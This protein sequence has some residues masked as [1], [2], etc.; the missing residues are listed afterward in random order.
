MNQPPGRP[1]LHI[2]KIDTNAQTLVL[3]VTVG[4]YSV[5]LK[6]FQFEVR[7]DAEE[8]YTASNSEQEG[9]A[10]LSN[11]LWDFDKIQERRDKEYKDF[12]R[13]RGNF[14]WAR[15]DDESVKLLQNQLQDAKRNVENLSEPI[16]RDIARKRVN[17]LDTQLRALLAKNP[18]QRFTQS[19]EELCFCQHMWRRIYQKQLAS[20]QLSRHDEGLT[21]VWSEQRQLAFT[22]QNYLSPLEDAIR[23]V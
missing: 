21:S 13:L 19:I 16:A 9:W 6:W 11:Y 8:I 15:Q 7:P 1:F 20:K 5:E 23:V 18:R 2:E 17:A 12:V 22:L 4:V 10:A 3:R 14:T